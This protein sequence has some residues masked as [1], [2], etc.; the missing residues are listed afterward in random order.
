LLGERFDCPV[1]YILSKGS[2][3]NI[4][5]SGNTIESIIAELN[6]ERREHKKIDQLLI[7]KLYKKAEEM[8]Q[9]SF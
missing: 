6:R 5:K 9:N 3:L 7:E 1:G 4:I 8:A 2:M